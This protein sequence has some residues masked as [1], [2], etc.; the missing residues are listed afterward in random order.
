MQVY[1]SLPG[2]PD[3]PQPPKQLKGF[4]RVELA[5]GA[6]APVSITL[7]ARSFSYWDS[8]THGWKVAPGTY[9]VLAAASSRDVK[10][11]QAVVMK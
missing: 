10:L 6:S 1:I 5:A 7:D 4:K 9:T 2:Q 11:Q 3:V 8:K